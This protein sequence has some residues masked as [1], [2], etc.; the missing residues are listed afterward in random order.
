MTGW[1]H[2]ILANTLIENGVTRLTM[3]G[4]KSEQSAGKLI[5]LWPNQHII[6][7]R[8]AMNI[9]SETHGGHKVKG[10]TLQKM[11]ID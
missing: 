2:I 6:I 8:L 10:F 5:K 1:K 9:L 11:F 7:E 3:P 4:G